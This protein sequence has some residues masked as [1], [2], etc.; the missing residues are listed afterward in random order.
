ME[1][2]SNGAE[3]LQAEKNVVL[4]NFNGQFV[5]WK[6]DAVDPK[7]VFAGSYFGKDY[8]AAIASFYERIGTTFN[9]AYTIAFEISGSHHPTGLDVTEAQLIDA[10]QK[11]IDTLRTMDAPYDTYEE[12][13]T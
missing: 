9:H 12:A 10:L 1:I 13:S 2:L 6:R 5:T 4:A 11:R 7:G 3:V 8:E